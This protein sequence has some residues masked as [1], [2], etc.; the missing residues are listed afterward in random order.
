MIKFRR[1]AVSPVFI[2]ITIIGSCAAFSSL[3]TSQLANDNIA[4][5]NTNTQLPRTMTAQLISLS[6]TQCEMA[7]VMV[8]NTWI[9]TRPLVQEHSGAA[10]VKAFDKEISETEQWIAQ[11]C[12]PSAS[13]GFI[14]SPDGRG[15]ELRLL[16]DGI[17]GKSEAGRN[18]SIRLVPAP[19]QD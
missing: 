18:G 9:N 5:A 17:P 4:F 6:R 13:R 8:A 2:V 10:A 3:I 12:P 11:G 7:A 16:P 15:G 1:F 19:R 14:P